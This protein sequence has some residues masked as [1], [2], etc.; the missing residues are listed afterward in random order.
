M[1]H[2][3]VEGKALGVDGV[4]DQEARAPHNATASTRN[5]PHLDFELDRRVATWE[6]Q[7]PMPLFDRTS[8]VGPCRRRP[9]AGF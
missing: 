9:P 3:H 1:A 4:V 5:G 7:D 6:M 8:R 2:P